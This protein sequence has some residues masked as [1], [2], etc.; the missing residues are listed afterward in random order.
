MLSLQT[1]I[2]DGFIPYKYSF[3]VIDRKTALCIVKKNTEKFVCIRSNEKIN[4]FEN[5]VKEYREENINIKIFRLTWKNY[6]LLTKYAK[7]IRPKKINKKISYG[8]ENRLNISSSA[9][10]KA[11]GKYDV[12]PV[13]VQNSQGEIRT[14]KKSYVSCLLDG[15]SGILENGYQGDWG[16]D[17]LITSEEDALNAS[18]AGF[19]KY[20]YNIRSLNE[21]ENFRN[22][23]PDPNSEY[24]ITEGKK[25][26]SS[27]PVYINFDDDNFLYSACRYEKEMNK[28]LKLYSSVRNYT[29]DFDFEI[30]LSAQ[31]QITDIFDFVYI[32][33]Y[34]ISAKADIKYISPKYE[35]EEDFKKLTD[36]LNRINE[37]SDIL[38]NTKLS[39]TQSRDCSV[40]KPFGSFHIK[41]ENDETEA[42]LVLCAKYDRK[43]FD[44]I[45]S[46]A[47][48]HTDSEVPPYN[49]EHPELFVTDQK[50]CNAFFSAANMI[51]KDLKDEIYA[52]CHK[53]EREY[54]LLCE[55]FTDRHFRI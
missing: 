5:T 48:H 47:K 31:E 19:S 49:Q 36:I 20:T 42:L 51:I 26:L 38:E 23:I 37:Y 15:V 34:F 9:H 10:I 43:L 2:N 53:Y 18:Q 52:L 55:K 33:L 32:V 40:G 7:N 24:A 6:L 1:I 28:I 16:A 29:N 13:I 45:Y 3:R 41:T 27:I 44:R 25:I 39:F 12:F 14:L 22:F 11:L 8:T 50:L 21:T 4:D 30:N 17:A 46:A 54:Y 35:K